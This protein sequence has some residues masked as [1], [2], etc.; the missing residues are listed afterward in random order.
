MWRLAT[1]PLRPRPEGRV[2]RVQGDSST[3]PPTE[4]PRLAGPRAV[5]HRLRQP[6]GR[7]GTRI[8]CPP[9]HHP[10]RSGLGT[11]SLLFRGSAARELAGAR[12]RGPLSGHIR[13]PSLTGVPVCRSTRRCPG[14]HVLG[15]AL[16]AR[17]RTGSRVPDFPVPPLGWGP[18]LVSESWVLPDP[19][20]SG[21][22]AD[23][24]AAMAVDSRQGGSGD[25]L[26]PEEEID[27]TLANLL[28]ASWPA[29]AIVDDQFRRFP[30]EP[31]GVSLVEQRYEAIDSRLMTHVW[32]IIRA[33]YGTL[34]AVPEGT[35]TDFPFLRRKED[36]QVCQVLNHL[37]NR[38]LPP[39][40]GETPTY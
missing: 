20:S 22:E 21:G 39:E 38:E 29:P 33:F 9:L 12:E 23:A 17:V 31:P 32:T 7:P 2:I 30:W 14:R 10:V 27:V 8:L 25:V 26:G 36:W 13:R 11:H 37:A 15:T 34:Y 28:S 18:P 40:V 6:G 4:G 5:C 24:A 35:G 3:Y 19:M 16:P 1:R